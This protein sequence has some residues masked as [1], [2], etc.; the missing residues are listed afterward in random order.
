[1]GLTTR[2][3][4][5]SSSFFFLPKYFLKYLICD[6][7][8]RVSDKRGKVWAA[9]WTNL[10]TKHWSTS[11]K[12]KQ[13]QGKEIYKS[14]GHEEGNDFFNFRNVQMM[15]LSSPM[16]L[17]CKNYLCLFNMK[18]AD[19]TNT[20]TLKPRPCRRKILVS[21]HHLTKYTCETHLPTCGIMKNKNLPDFEWL[22]KVEAPLW[23]PL[24]VVSW[25]TNLWYHGFEG[26]HD[27]GTLGLLVVG[28]TSSHHDYCSQDDT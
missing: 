4:F 2:F 24:M 3:H 17:I 7:N 28:E 13:V 14:H 20:E 27:S 8:S 5:F 18:N 12:Q 15:I 22:N 9:L 11:T 21:H 26:I 25:A 23:R 1:M 10:F 19:F 6:S 16:A